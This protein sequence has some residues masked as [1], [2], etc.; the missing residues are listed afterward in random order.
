[1]PRCAGAPWHDAQLVQ[2]DQ[3]ELTCER[4]NHGSWPDGDYLVERS[5]SR[6]SP[7]GRGSVIGTITRAVMP[8]I[9][10]AGGKRYGSG[11]AAVKPG[12][13]ERGVPPESPK[14]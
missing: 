13:P 11:G 4:G 6:V 3:H 10:R 7:K 1:M 14:L 2:R 5:A 9:D 8:V 12:A